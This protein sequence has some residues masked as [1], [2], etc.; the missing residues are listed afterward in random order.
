MVF[1]KYYCEIIYTDMTY[2][3]GP[4]PKHNQIQ[5]LYGTILGGS[6]IV[7]PKRGKNCYLA[8]RDRNY[9]WLCYKIEELRNFFKVDEKLIK[10]DKNTYRCYS[11]AYPIFNDLYESFYQNY[12]KII[13][14]E[15][16]EILNDVAWMT[17]FLDAGRKSKKKAYLRTN[18][19][20]KE[21]TEII[22]NYFNSLDCECD[23]HLYRGRYEIIFSNNGSFVLL[24]TI[25]HRFP[26]FM[27]KY[28]E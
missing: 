13:K 6:S 5:F 15:L 27:E 4:I 11:V 12:K 21:G 19:F 20:G 23:I 7:K 14:R 3:I 22:C 10:R 1:W 2:Q 8:M 26:K 17:W 25:G 28:L 9:D 16:L 18:K 24:T